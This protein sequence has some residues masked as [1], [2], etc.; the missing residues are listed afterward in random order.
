M[1]GA[2]TH[3]E[4]HKACAEAV[5]L[6]VLSPGVGSVVLQ[7]CH[8]AAQIQRTF[9]VEASDGRKL[10]LLEGFLRGPIR[11]GLREDAD[12]HNR[13][14]R[15]NCSMAPPLPELR[16]CSCQRHM[17]TGPN[18]DQVTDEGLEQVLDTA[19]QTRLQGKSRGSLREEA[20]DKIS[21]ETIPLVL[22]VKVT[23]QFFSKEELGAA[24]K[25]QC[26]FLCLVAH[27]A[28]QETKYCSCWK[29]DIIPRASSHQGYKVPRGIP[30][31]GMGIY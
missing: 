3:V 17:C 30:S 25:T 4:L 13:L 9:S 19:E 8:R 15:C 12:T 20:L 29:V 16:K 31:P 26:L 27:K 24:M 18:Q 11:P 1:T 10:F 22:P 21:L 28:T 6:H 5:T 2:W 7:T 14:D 23:H